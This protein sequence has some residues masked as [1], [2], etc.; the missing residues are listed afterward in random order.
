MVDLNKNQAKAAYYDGNKY[1]VIE[2]GPGSGKT[3]VLIERIKF[4][5]NEKDVDPSTLL[6]I[7][8]TRKAADELKERLSNDIDES[9]LNLMQISTIHA[10]CRVMLSNIGE[11]NTRILS[12]SFNERIKMFLYKYRKDLGF[13]KECTIRP[14]EI[15]NLIKKYNEYATFKVNTDELVNYISENYKVQSDYIDF[16]NKY[17]DHHNG[18]FPFNEVKASNSFKESRKNALYLQIAKSY[19][20]YLELLDEKRF[21]DFNQM[22]IK[23]LDY[24]KENPKT[25]YTNILVDE[26]Q[27]TD[28]VQMKIFEILMKEAVS[29]TVVG[30][31]DQSIYGFRGANKNYFEYLYN[32]YDDKVY[33][34]NLNVNYRSANQIIHISEDFIKSQRTTGAKQD[35]AIGARNLDRDSYFFVSEGSENES[36]SIFNMISYLHDSGKIENYNEISI[37]SRSIKHNK[38]AKALIQLFDN[39]KIPYHIR[40]IPDLFDKPEIRSIL[41]LIFHLIQDEN[42]QNHKFY[43]WEL[44]WLNLKAFTGENFNQ[45]LFNLSD[46]TKNILNTLQENFEKELFDKEKDVYLKIKGEK[47]HIKG[48]R[49]VFN[50]ENDVLVELFKNVERPILTD[51]NL[52]KFGVTNKEDLDFFRKLNKLKNY[53]STKDY[54]DSDDTI[55]DILIILLTDVCNYLTEDRINDF[56]YR[57]ELENLAIISNTFYNYELIVDKKNLKGVF[58]FLRYNIHNYYTNADENEGIQLMTIHKSKGLEFPIVILLSLDEK[59]FPREFKEKK[60]SYHTP[61]SFLEYKNFTSKEEEIIEYDQEEERIVYVAMTRA[62]DTLILSNLIKKSSE[63]NKLNEELKEELSEIEKK[64]IIQEIP[65]G[66]FKIQNLINNNLNEFK[67][68]QDDFSII[69]KT[70]CEKPPIKNEKII[71][72]SFK[73][74]EDYIYCPFKYKL[75]HDINFSEST[76]ESNKLMGLFLHNILETI[77]KKIGSNN[78]QYIGDDEVL[79]VIDNFISSFKFQNLKLSNS[80]INI[81]K[82]NVLY[83]YNT[84]GRDFLVKNTEQ[85]FNIKNQLYQ[86]SGIIDLI[87]ETKNGKIGLLDYKNTDLISKNY[88]KKYIKQLYIYLIGLNDRLKIDELKIYAIKS[89]KMIN[90]NLKEELLEILLEELDLVSLNI[91]KEIFKCNMDD[92]CYKC[93]FSK[94]CFKSNNNGSVNYLDK[95]L[96]LTFHDK[97]YENLPDYEIID[98]KDEYWTDIEFNNSTHFKSNTLP[99][100]NSNSNSSNNNSALKLSNFNI[101][102]DNCHIDEIIE[103]FKANKNESNIKEMDRLKIYSNKKYG[104]KNQ[105]LAKLAKKIGNNHELALELWQYDCHESKFLAILIEDPLLTSNDQLNQWVNDFDNYH[106]VDHACKKLLVNIPFAINKIPIWAKSDKELI[107]RTAFSFIAVLASQNNKVYNINFEEFFPIIIEASS[108]DRKYVI[109]SVKWALVSI[110]RLNEYFNM[111]AIAVSNEINQLDFKSAKWIAKKSLK[112][113]KSNKVQNSF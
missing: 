38:T 15:Y 62:Q 69:P 84:F 33:K 86:L 67:Y 49:G 95:D 61:I 41:T 64:D 37:L 74:L 104:I 70:V 65:K 53:I 17:M 97:F 55:L 43:K 88:I 6:V 34:V 44:E 90:I 26:F 7:T 99:H 5:I 60:E 48:F 102:G 59:R 103:Y 89:R 54:Q 24:L 107:K 19:P 47:S 52:I 72:L 109:K 101:K 73:S 106:I 36:K 56:D 11:Y 75:V 108:D 77:N 81:I 32:N 93:S 4:L 18:E 91:Q 12:D 25:Q 42:P 76:L 66:H 58:H 21:S 28:P 78:N 92:D 29:F 1:L 110:G 83:Y 79:Q 80:D 57:E 23:T 20:K 100:S 22:Q 35:A 111:R 31:I 82:N 63:F 96:I 2:A 87:Y 113:L 45:V 51:D 105:D 39:N 10:F 30:D 16:V 98:L 14:T 9:D 8:F 27:D 3:R 94:I 68:L 50:R 85:S 13:D 112:E 46:E 40:G 71:N